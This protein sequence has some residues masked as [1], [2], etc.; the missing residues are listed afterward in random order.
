MPLGISE[1]FLLL[2]FQ[3]DHFH[4]IW[5]TFLT[6]VKWNEI[7]KFKDFLLRREGQ[8]ALYHQATKNFS[9]TLKPLHTRRNIPPKASLQPPSY[10]SLKTHCKYLWGHEALS[11]DCPW[12]EVILLS[13][14]P[15]CFFLLRHI[16]FDLCK[17]LLFLLLISD[18]KM[19]RLVKV[20][21][22]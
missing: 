12:K 14:K 10:Q 15:L 4:L 5:E 17:V 11:E 1:L 16:Y 19:M 18:S 22:Y 7:L 9:Q 3:L 2:D 6:V 20:I 21:I 13:S 8:Q